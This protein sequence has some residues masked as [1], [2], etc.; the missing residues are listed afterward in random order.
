MGN[1]VYTSAHSHREPDDNA[2]DF[3]EPVH[4][5]DNGDITSELQPKP[6]TVWV[7]I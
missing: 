6:K 7:K 1:G 3:G 5:S 2:L 4:Q